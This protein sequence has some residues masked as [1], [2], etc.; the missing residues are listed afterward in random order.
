M[1]VGRPP[2]PTALK[3]L[4]GNPGKRPLNANEPKPAQKIPSCPRHLGKEGRKEWRRISAQLLKL[5]LLTEID[6]A[7]L[8]GY[9]VAW[10]RWVESEEALRKMGM[11]IKTPNGYPIVNPLLSVATGAMKQMKVFLTEFGM[12]PS[13]RSRVTVEPTAEGEPGA[14]HREFFFGRRKSS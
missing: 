13:S 5:K 11:L 9:C 4:A 1:K 12:T 8:A 2:I 3:V 6:R 14:T 10:E 7:A